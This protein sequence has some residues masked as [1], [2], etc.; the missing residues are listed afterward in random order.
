[1]RVAPVFD[2]PASSPCLTPVVILLFYSGH[3]GGYE[4][5]CGDMNLHFP[6]DWLSWAC[7]HVLIRCLYIFVEM[8]IWILCPFLIGLSFYY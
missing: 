6:D 2:S 7:F 8:S 5:A 1:M 4:M 3:L